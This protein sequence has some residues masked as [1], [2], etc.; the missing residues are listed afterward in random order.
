MAVMI[1]PAD[2]VRLDADGDYVTAS[3]ARRL[4]ALADRIG[5]P[6]TYGEGRIVAECEVA[7]ASALGKERA[8]LF[9]TGTLANLVALDRLCGP[10]RR[11][12]LLHPDSHILNDTGDS[13]VSGMGLMPV[14]ARPS[15]AG[16]APEELDAAIARAASG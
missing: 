11:R 6:D 16:F 15:G 2:P 3:F 12:V 9:P 7:L 1:D 4:A 13:L 8:V 10:K 14:A 5:E